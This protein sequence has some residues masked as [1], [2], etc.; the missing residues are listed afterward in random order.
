M[1]TGGVKMK[2]V[3]L[4][5]NPIA[6]RNSTRPS[7]DDIIHAFREYD[8][9]CFEKITTCQ[10]DG[11]TIAKKYAADYDAVVCCGGDGTYNEVVNGLMQEGI[12]KPVVYIPCGSTNDFAHSL[13][14]SKD[15]KDVAKLYAEGYQNR[16][17]IG[18]F[19]DKYFCYIASFGMATEISYNTSQNIK[20]MFGHSAYL[21]NGFVLKLIP[22]IK[23]MKPAHMRV[24]YDGGVI[25]GDFYFGAVAN[26][27]EISGLFKLEKNNV[28]MNDGLFE[29]LLVKG[30]G[31][32]DVADAFVCA[33]RQDYSCENIFLVKT[34]KVK[35]TTEDN[36]PW[37]LD[38]EYG[39]A[40]NEI[41]I[42][43]KKE[44]VNVVSP[45]GRFLL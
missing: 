23:N 36:V 27:N 39:G 16:Y 33:L 28:K 31:M 29:L 15:P 4:I 25:E 14:L 41:E 2:N 30:N 44:A 24:E 17:D 5:K 37:T 3:L 13:S 38:G 35:I 19:N 34:S 43:V 40:Y 42:D 6:G 7:T 45:K 22:M 11:I 20:N 10:G 18:S 8:I 21:I 1:T 32:K 12:D 26:T 9:E